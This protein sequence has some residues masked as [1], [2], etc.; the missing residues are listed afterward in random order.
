M[1]AAGIA[2]YL[3]SSSEKAPVKEVVQAPTIEVL[4][5][6]SEIGLGHSVTPEKLQWQAWPQSTTGAN[7]IRRSER[8]DATTQLAGAIARAPF[9]E[10]EPIREA[11]LVPLNGTGFMAAILPTGMRAISTPISPEIGA[12]GFILPNDRVDVI[13]SKRD[14]N[15]D[16]VRSQI[17][18]RNM[19]VLAIDQAPKEKDGQNAV[20]GRTATLEATPD[21]AE[22]LARAHMRGTLSLALR[23]ITDGEHV[24]KPSNKTIAIYR[25][26]GSQS[27][28]N[29][30]PSCDLQ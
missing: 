29:C 8:P 2:A 20:I 30:A 26:V 12:G 4:V 1:G 28:Y 11:K 6:R 24:G 25:G 17:I 14:K 22:T 18:L 23:S 9:V 5:A 10:G 13:L 16:S 3:A 7:F 21:Q 19:R 15:T 27:V